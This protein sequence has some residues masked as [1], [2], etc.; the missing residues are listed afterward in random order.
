MTTTVRSSRYNAARR[1]S[2]NSLEVSLVLFEGHIR[3]EKTKIS[4]DQLKMNAMTSLP[5]PSEILAKGEDGRGPAAPSSRKDGAR[6]GCRNIKCIFLP[7]AETQ[8]ITRY[9]SIA[10]RL[11]D[12]TMQ[13]A[14]R[15]GSQWVREKFGKPSRQLEAGGPAPG[16]PPFWARDGGGSA[17]DSD[18]MHAAH[19]ITDDRN[20][21]LTCVDY[22]ATR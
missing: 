2:V 14:L 4:G 12:V 18:A 19:R 21:H 13:T 22:R 10:A 11:S 20:P 5:L 15:R 6:I 8:L 7:E 17:L 3:A 9:R 16:T 1:V